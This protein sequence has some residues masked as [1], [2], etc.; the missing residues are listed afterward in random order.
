[1]TDKQMKERLED[2]LN[3]T[4]AGLDYQIAREAV[5]RRIKADY[6]QECQ[7]IR[8]QLLELEKRA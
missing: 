8:R 6:L 4:R 7:S 3:R 2:L 5:I 1:M